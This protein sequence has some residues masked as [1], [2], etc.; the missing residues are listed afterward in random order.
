[1]AASAPVVFNIFLIAV[2]VYGNLLGD[3]LVYYLSYVVTIA[4]ITQFVY[5]YFYVRKFYLPKFSFKV[6]IDDKIKNFFSKL[7]PSIF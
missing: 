5:L 7:L 4:G 6:L 1:M 2:L 3:S